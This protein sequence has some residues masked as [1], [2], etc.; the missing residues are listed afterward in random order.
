[1][2]RKTVALIE[3]T[4][5]LTVFLV[6]SW[7]FQAIVPEYS[8]WYSKAIMILLALAGIAIHGRPRDYGLW[9]RN[10]KTTAKWSLVILT[11]FAVVDAALLTV[12]SG[13]GKVSLGGFLKAALWYYVFVGFSEEL[14][15]RGYVQSRLNEVFTRKYKRIFGVD[16]EWTQGTLITAVFF[17][18]LPHLLVGVNPF[19][20]TYRLNP[21]IAALA[22]FATVLGLAAGVLREK[23][24]GVVL[25]AV[26]HGS[27]VFTGFGLS[28][29]A[30][31]I[32][33]NLAVAV[34][35]CA[36]FALFFER[37]LREED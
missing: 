23:T 17:F 2:S 29:A 7:Y 32:A 1:V 35:L 20:G 6:V 15:F 30:G 24:G 3:V 36:F 33:S 8:G 13:L 34:A 26:L 12:T 9:P 14:F 37:I 19:A 28:R 5:F 31:P 22:V 4:A 18:S 27:V 16:Y 10:P 21:E 25:P 11:L